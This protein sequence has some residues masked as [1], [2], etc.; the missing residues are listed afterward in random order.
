MLMAGL[1]LQNSHVTAH[2]PDFFY[3]KLNASYNVD[4]QVKCLRFREACSFPVA[5]SVQSSGLE[6]HVAAF[7]CSNRPTFANLVK[8]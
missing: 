2:H 1:T 7:S 4:L 6:Q 5:Q 8:T 3:T